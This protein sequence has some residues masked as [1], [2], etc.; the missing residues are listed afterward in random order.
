MAIDLNPSGWHILIVDDDEDNQRVA[1]DFLKFMGA[2]VRV[3]SDG[4]QGLALLEEFTPTFILLDLSMP[5]MDGW[6][7]INR[8]RHIPKI[9]NLP[10]IALT[11]HAMPD[12]QARAIATGFD[13]YITKPFM[14]TSLI[15]DIK[16]YLKKI[17]ES[18]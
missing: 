13:G 5:G 6:E 1:A 17:D 11:A 9:A 3:A 4:A 15:D 10:V 16:E 8:L 12:I 14:L 2:D 18:G 7:M